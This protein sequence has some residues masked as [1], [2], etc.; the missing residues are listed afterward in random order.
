MVLPCS[1]TATILH[2]VDMM[3]SVKGKSIEAAGY[4]AQL[5]LYSY[6]NIY[7]QHDQQKGNAYSALVAH[8]PYQDS[9]F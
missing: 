7:I 4:S 6:Y 8:P 5:P 9:G 2:P 1:A 3:F